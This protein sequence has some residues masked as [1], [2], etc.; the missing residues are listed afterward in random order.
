MAADW[1]ALQR[2]QG[3]KIGL[4]PTMGALHSGHIAL[5]EAARAECDVVAVSIFVNPLQFNDKED[6]A[7]YPRHPEEDQRMLQ[8]AG[9]DMVLMPEGDG[10]F[11]NFSPMH[12]ELGGLDTVLEGKSRPGHF[13]GVVNVVERLFHYVRPD[14]AIFGEKDRQQLAIIQHVAKQLRWPVV[15]EPHSIMRAEDGLAL[16][17][18]NQRL[19]P[20]HREEAS[21]LY[22]ALQAVGANAFKVS[23]PEALQHGLAVLA[24]HPEIH[25]DY[26]TIA[27]TETLQPL[28]SW[29]GRETAAALIAAQVGPVRL[30]DN[31]TLRR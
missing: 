2:R 8:A 18:R 16:S 17:S 28:E 25:L 4:V 27:D 1:S 21:A 23:V 31:I 3:L 6:L 9:C 10:L 15:I 5:V 20:D 24:E 29:E 30:I 22:L 11:K 19:S 13:Q 12:F 26:L 7:R 14:V